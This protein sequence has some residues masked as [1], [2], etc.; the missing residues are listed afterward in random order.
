MI[1]QEATVS[2]YEVIDSDILFALALHVLVV[3]GFLLLA[4]YTPA[5]QKKPLKR[6]EVNLITA[7]ELAKMQRPEKIVKQTPKPAPKVPEPI[8]PKIPEPIKPVPVKKTPPPI[9][10]IKPKMIEPTL[11]VPP[12][13]IAPPKT[14]AKPETKKPKP[15]PKKPAKRVEKHSLEKP[16]DPFAPAVSKRTH[17]PR[18]TAPK[19]DRVALVSHQLSS[20]ELDRYIAMMQ[21]AVQKHW[22]VPGGLPS[23]VR[24]PLVRLELKRDGGVLRITVLETSGSASLDQTLIVAIRAAAPFTLPREQYAVFKSNKIRFHPRKRG[25]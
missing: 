16:F 1:K 14:Q 19:I 5:E 8:K 24:S 3:G 2:S 23:G 15:T 21:A 9:D 11:V 17:Q 22:K 18:H 12:K 7:K 6:I 20:R 25:G 4:L 10:L 13:P